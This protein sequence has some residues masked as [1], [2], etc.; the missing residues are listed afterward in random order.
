MFCHQMVATVYEVDIKTDAGYAVGL[1]GDTSPLPNPKAAIFR[2]SAI[3]ATV[4]QECL[5]TE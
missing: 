2:N 4:M 1:G 3:M 5:A